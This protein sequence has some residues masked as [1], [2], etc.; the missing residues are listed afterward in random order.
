MEAGLEAVC[1]V[2]LS[3]TFSFLKMGGC[4]DYCETNLRTRTSSILA[5]PTFS[6]FI[7]GET[8]SWQSL[9]TLLS[10]ILAPFPALLFC[11]SSLPPIG[12]TGS[13]SSPLVPHTLTKGGV[14][15]FPSLSFVQPSPTLGVTSMPHNE[16]GSSTVS[17]STRLRR[18]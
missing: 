10:L 14:I 9:S 15:S 17:G 6:R 11:Y 5:R 13:K 4:Q 3:V 1:V 8:T 12:K 18:M 16:S 2:G 7:I